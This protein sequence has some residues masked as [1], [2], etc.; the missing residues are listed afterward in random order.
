MKSCFPFRA[1]E[2]YEFLCESSQIPWHI[3]DHH[4]SSPAHNYFKY[5]FDAKYTFTQH[6]DTPFPV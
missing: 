1:V 4:F 6:L 2:L 5:E 3:E